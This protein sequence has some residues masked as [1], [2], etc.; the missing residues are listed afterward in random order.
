MAIKK[1]P[2][3]LTGRDLDIKF[4]VFPKSTGMDIFFCMNQKGDL[5]HWRV[6]MDETD[7]YV[8]GG[9]GDMFKSPVILNEWASFRFS[10]RPVNSRDHPCDRHLT[11]EVNGKTLV[12]EGC[13]QGD[14][15]LFEIHITKAEACVSGLEAIRR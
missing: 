15:C 2:S 13:V 5:R 3:L 6:E 7:W 12:R 1:M 10:I 8:K 9:T 4:K 14:S 11:V